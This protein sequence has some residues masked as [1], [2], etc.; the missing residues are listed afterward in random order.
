M[1]LF[2]WRG[3]VE[4]AEALFGT[5]EPTAGLAGLLTGSELSVDDFMSTV[6][7]P[8]RK[9]CRLARPRPASMSSQYHEKKPLHVKRGADGKGFYDEANARSTRRR[10]PHAER[11]SSQV[12][13]IWDVE[14]VCRRYETT[15][16]VGHSCCPLAVIETRVASPRPLENIFAAVPP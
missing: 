3:R 7:V 11:F 15:T 13:S 14:P 9:Y 2:T 4:D 1:L 6:S 12:F 8:S 10:G 16:N 5:M